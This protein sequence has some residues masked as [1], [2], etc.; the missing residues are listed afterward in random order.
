MCVDHCLQ[1]PALSNV[2]CAAKILGVGDPNAAYTRFD[3]ETWRK[4]LE[5]EL[6][7]SGLPGAIQELT[8][9]MVDRARI[10]ALLSETDIIIKQLTV[11]R[12]V[13]EYVMF[14]YN[15]SSV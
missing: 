11:T 1:N 10:K 2:Q 15:S 9:E 6:R 7:D 8:N 3:I 4:K 5:G 13:Q 14:Q 12:N